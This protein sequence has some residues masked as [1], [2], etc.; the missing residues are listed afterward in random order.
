MSLSSVYL[1][2]KTMTCLLNQIKLKESQVL[3]KARGRSTI[4]VSVM[5]SETDMS[6]EHSTVHSEQ[7]R[8]GYCDEQ[9]LAKVSEQVVNVQ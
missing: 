9:A 2:D 4:C 6:K 8:Y 5:Q 1:V 7:T 3:Q